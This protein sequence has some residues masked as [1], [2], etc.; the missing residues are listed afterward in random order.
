M[1]HW[2][3]KMTIIL[4]KKEKKILKRLLLWDGGS[5]SRLY[6][7][8]DQSF[9]YQHSFNLV[10]GWLKKEVKTTKVS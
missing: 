8:F 3:P 1:L 10:I 9:D 7:L 6:L 4:K 5:I 2:Y